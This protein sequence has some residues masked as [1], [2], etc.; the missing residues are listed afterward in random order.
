[1]SQRGD[2]DASGKKRKRLKTV[3]LRSVAPRSETRL[4]AQ[5]LARVVVVVTAKASLRSHRA[6][7]G[8]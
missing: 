5:P 7:V 4:L 8:Q 3:G 2:D 6:H 1:M